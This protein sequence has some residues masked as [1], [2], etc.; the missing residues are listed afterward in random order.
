MMPE[1][2]QLDSSCTMSEQ[3]ESVKKKTL[4][5]SSRSSLFSTGLIVIYTIH[6]TFFFYFKKVDPLYFA[7]LKFNTPKLKHQFSLPGEIFSLKMLCAYIT[8]SQTETYRFLWCYN[9]SYKINCLKVYPKRL[10]NCMQC[11]NAYIFILFM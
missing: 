11:L 5:S 2:H 3:Q 10:S 8:A 7:S 1:W 9:N 6:E 4:K